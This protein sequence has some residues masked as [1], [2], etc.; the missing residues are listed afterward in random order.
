MPS[1]LTR[2][3]VMLGSAMALASGAIVPAA[4]QESL[5]GAGMPYAAF[6]KLPH[7][8]LQVQESEIAIGF[9]DGPMKLSKPD[10]L[11][12]IA[13]SARAVSL[14]YGRFPVGALKLLVLPV[15]GNG[16]PYGQTWG[17]PAAIRIRV[18]RD[19]DAAAL[20]ADWVM[21]HEMVHLAFPR[22][23]RRH[24]WLA[25]GL[26]VYVESIA[27]I[28]SGDLTEMHVWREFK[29]RMPHGLPKAGDQ[30]LDN[31]HTWGRTYWGG[32]IFCLTADVEIRKATENKMGLQHA[33]RAVNRK[34]DYNTLWPIETALAT[35]D[36][37][38][39]MPV[40]TS[41]Y[42][43]LKDSPQMP[44]LD[45]LWRDLGV[46]GEGGVFRLEP[47]APLA[48]IRQAICMPA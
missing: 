5:D 8:R 32:A 29:E 24:N 37:E 31:T 42:A 38:I 14:Y 16:V 20:T 18:G 33:L 23:K 13:H 10:I 22:L 35:G 47:T 1:K 11:T 27:R 41:L 48:G 34:V 36:A 44:D 4:G 15:D 19:A 43:R 45:A 3:T 25:E 21:V 2:R 6:D 7:E 9:G 40:L 17:D 30:G 26:A 46:V 12:W 39:G 28:Q